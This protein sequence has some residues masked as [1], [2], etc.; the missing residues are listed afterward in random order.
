[1]LHPTFDQDPEDPFRFLWSEA[2]KND[3]TFLR[4]LGKSSSTKI[5]RKASKLAENFTI[6][7]YGK[8]GNHY[9]EV[10]KGISVPFKVSKKKFGYSSL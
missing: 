6:K 4:P 9:L 3:D 2:Y 1:M 5:F 10:R 7:V 8:F